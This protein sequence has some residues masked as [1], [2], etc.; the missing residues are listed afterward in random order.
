MQINL[1]EI[2]KHISW[3]IRYEAGDMPYP[4]VLF[5]K[6][7]IHFSDIIASWKNT[8]E[9]I[10]KNGK[11]HNMGLYVHLPFCYTHCFFCT[12]VMKVSHNED[13]YEEYLDMLESEAQKYQEVFREVQF[14]TVYVWWGTPTILTEKQLERF[15]SILEKYFNIGNVIQIMTEW[16]PYTTT[17][18]KL[19]ILRA[20]WVNKLTFWV[21]SLDGVTLKQN[22]RAQQI[23]HVIEAV[24]NAR[25]VG[26]QYI[27][28]D[29]MA[30]LPWQT[31][32][33]FE[34]TIKIIE[35]E[36]KPTTVHV[37]GF[38]PTKNTIFDKTKQ[39]Y[40]KE[41][42]A[43]RNKMREIGNYLEV[44]KNATHHSLQTHNIQLYNA[45]NFNSSI[46]WLGYWAISHAYGERHY[47]KISFPEYKSW[48]QKWEDITFS[49]YT[50]TIEDE[51][52]TYAINNIRWGISSKKFFELFSQ[53]LD[54]SILYKKIELLLK[55]RVIFRYTDDEWI[56]CFKIAKD[57]TIISTVYAKFFY[58]DSLTR[59]CIKV[60]LKDN[61]DPKELDDKLELFFTSD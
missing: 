9:I 31:I 20:H 28:L 49:W 25:A 42:I 3:K 18:E 19:K 32:E 57:T 4:P 10:K 47:A 53:S 8:I 13:E 40:T 39:E 48:I 43:L 14:N 56:I 2:Y 41:H 59:E 38:L 5:W 30:G 27:N 35:S 36:I 16:S 6:K 34:E 22:N 51:M 1:L 11:E 17:L 52:R 50:V 24:K 23:H 46:L 21:Q 33:S 45:K 29:I 60:F 55:L 12:C 61:P 7:N 15:Y 58:S 54:R 37:N 26:I 44:E